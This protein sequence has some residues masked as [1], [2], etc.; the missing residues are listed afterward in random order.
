MAWSA[1][2]SKGSNQKL[3]IFIKCA[4]SLKLDMIQDVFLSENR[5]ILLRFKNS[6][7]NLNSI[8]KYFKRLQKNDCKKYSGMYLKLI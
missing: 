5:K 6:I 8:V 3:F 4:V 7:M 1:K 2:M